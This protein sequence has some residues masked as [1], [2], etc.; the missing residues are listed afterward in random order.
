MEDS[1]IFDDMDDIFNNFIEDAEEFICN[2]KK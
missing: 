1:N 2:L